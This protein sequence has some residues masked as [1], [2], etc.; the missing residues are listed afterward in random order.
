MGKHF[1]VV[2]VLVDRNLFQCPCKPG[3]EI[4]KGTCQNC[5]K[6]CDEKTEKCEIN[7]ETDE[8]ECICRKG[9]ELDEALGLCVG[10]AEFLSSEFGQ[11]QEQMINYSLT[12][13]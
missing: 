10:K 4:Y 13:D 9:Y 2:L 3:Y 1:D 12:K 11:F 5:E 6:E 7:E 8:E